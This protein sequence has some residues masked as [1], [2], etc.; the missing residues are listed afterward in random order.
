M[1]AGGG[2]ALE[3]SRPAARARAR[4]L[5]A[6][7]LAGTLTALVPAGSALGASRSV[8]APPAQTAASRASSQGAPAGAYFPAV[9]ARIVDTRCSHSPTPSFCAG[10]NLPPAN[11]SLGTLGP[12]G[13]RWSARQ[14]IDQNQGGQLVSCTGPKFCMVIGGNP[15]V[16]GT[17]GA[18]VN[19]A[20]YWNGSSWSSPQ[21]IGVNADEVTALSCASSSFCVAMDDGG[22]A[23]Y[24][25]GS[26]WSLPQI[27]DQSGGDGSVSCPTTTFCMAVDYSG[28]ALT[29]NGSTW[30]APVSVDPGGNVRS[31]SCPTTGF[32][33]AVDSGGNAMFF[34]DMLW[35]SPEP[36]DPNGGGLFSVSCTSTIFCTAADYFGKVVTW[37]GS[38]WSAVTSIGDQGIYAYADPLSCASSSFCVLVDNAGS[39]FTYDGTAWSPPE[40]AD[41][42]NGGLSSVS[43]PSTSYCMAV[44]NVGGAV[45]A[46][47][48]PPEQTITAQ[49]SGSGGVPSSATAAVLDV[50]VTNTTSAGYL[51]VY[52]AGAVTPETSNLNWTK[53]ETVANLVE[54]ELPTSG[55]VSITMGGSAGSADVVVDL[56]GYSAPPTS[57]APG[58]TFSPMAPERLVDT[59]C[60]GTAFE[61]SNPSY[62][63]G[64]PN[65]VSPAAP[66]PAGSSATVTLPAALSS[67]GVLVANL[68]VANP[69][70]G[71][72]LTMYPAGTS[73]PPTSNVDFS[74]GETAANR[75][76]VQAAGGKVDIYNGSSAPVQVVL[77]A[78]GTYTTSTSGSL[79]TGQVPTRTADTRC[80]ASPPPSF[81]AGENLPPQNSGLAAPG[82][83]GTLT[84][85]IAGTGGVPSGATAVVANVTAVTPADPGYLSV[86]PAGSARPVI[87]DVNFPE[88]V[89]AVPNLVVVELGSGGGIDIYNG[90]AGTV[91][92]VVDVVGW[93][94]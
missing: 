65:Q 38:S 76:E 24:F 39:S 85:A 92:V 12:G 52:P 89:A 40:S 53:G 14:S 25:D 90:S 5:P 28:M 42:G 18:V 36:V 80:A 43:C 51:T 78:N 56:E 22:D 33:A 86:Y 19:E 41:P 73:R 79:F 69:Q 70:A 37:N 11:A 93:Y 27:V 61:Q 26:S 30:S 16:P 47:V 59:R 84:I 15:S 71:G 49:V 31:V 32:C 29:F 23:M 72:Y 3:S 88:G 50:A 77:D 44:D 45:Q 83:G 17:N 20:L 34:N 57:S 63:K 75:V 2:G 62:C 35:G 48:A 67:S 91:E 13:P 1:R 4:L 8:Q 66:I 58:E 54:V 82:G 55:Q 21:A 74:A 64:V 6:V 60:F 9:P 81:C 68:T 7:V 46:S 10:E 94:G 87:S